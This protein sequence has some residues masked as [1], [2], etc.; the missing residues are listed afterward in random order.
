MY[1]IIYIVPHT[2]RFRIE[3]KM[4]NLLGVVLRRLEFALMM[5]EMLK[6]LLALSEK[7]IK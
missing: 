4:E 5:M 6:C 1:V 7:T 2:G 3:L